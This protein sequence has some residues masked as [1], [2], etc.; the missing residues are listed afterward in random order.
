MFFPDGGHKSDVEFDVRDFK[1]NPLSNDVSREMI[2]TTVEL[3]NFALS[4]RCIRSD[5]D[6]G[7]DGH[8]SEPDLVPSDEK[9]RRPKSSASFDG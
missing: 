2:H 4:E 5:D 9:V 3:P 1:L 8:V 7:Y 6:P